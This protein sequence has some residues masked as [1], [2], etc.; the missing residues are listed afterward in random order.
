MSCK[1][2][3]E[4][5][6]AA[7]EPLFGSEAP[8]QEASLQTIIKRAE[9]SL[10]SAIVYFV[11]VLMSFPCRSLMRPRG[12]YA[13]IGGLFRHIIA[14]EEANPLFPLFVSSFSREYHSTSL[15]RPHENGLN[16][17]GEGTVII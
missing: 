15:S 17:R 5:S 14:K 6:L 10:L 7:L 13:T 2:I 3:S 11:R 16:E 9:L 12:I 8:E 4:E 1:Q